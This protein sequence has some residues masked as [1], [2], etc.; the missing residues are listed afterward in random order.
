MCQ[1][2]AN[3]DVSIVEISLFCLV[4]MLISGSNASQKIINDLQSFIINIDISSVVPCLMQIVF[5]VLAD[6]TFH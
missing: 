4:Q 3:Y 1:H 2:A 6:W 5:F